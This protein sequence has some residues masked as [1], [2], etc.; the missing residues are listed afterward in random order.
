MD[1]YLKIE[2]NFPNLNLETWSI[3]CQKNT[4]AQG[5][6]LR[7]IKI[8]ILFP[9]LD[10]PGPPSLKGRAFAASFIEKRSPISLDPRQPS[11]RK[12]LA[13]TTLG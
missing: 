12:F 10:V 8:Q 7:R 4:K 5:M 2:V 11:P 13:L 9:G 3:S 1:N 6:A